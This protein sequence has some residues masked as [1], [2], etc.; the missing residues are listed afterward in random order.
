MK[1]VLAVVL[2][3]MLLIQIQSPAVPMFCV[4]AEEEEGEGTATEETADEYPSPRW[5][6]GRLDMRKTFDEIAGRNS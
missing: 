1:R 5:G 2:G 4:Y 3:L 6:Y